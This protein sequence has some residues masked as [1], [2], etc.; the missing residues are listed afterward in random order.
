[1]ND[2]R[3]ATYQYVNVADL[4]EA[5]ARRKRILQSEHEGVMERPLPSS[6]QQL[7]R[8]S[9][10]TCW[11]LLTVGA[12]LECTYHHLLPFLSKRQIHHLLQ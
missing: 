1:M 9:D 6:L 11:N 12:L 3:E 7:L 8:T 10:A 2:L 4:T 5:A